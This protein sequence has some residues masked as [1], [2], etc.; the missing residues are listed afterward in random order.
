MI[1]ATA[2][3]ATIMGVNFLVLANRCF[4]WLF[5]KEIFTVVKIKSNLL[6]L[7]FCLIFGTEVASYAGSTNY[8]PKTKE[9]RI[10]IMKEH[11]EK[12]KIKNPAKYETMMKDAGG[13][14]TKCTDCH[15]ELKLKEK[16]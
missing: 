9:E 13:S 8:P 15:T 1:T 4:R 2:V 16:P 6:I 12:V 5:G 3:N 7:C 10:K 11:M 14:V